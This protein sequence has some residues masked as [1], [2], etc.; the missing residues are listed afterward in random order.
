MF[1]IAWGHMA[2]V[3]A[4]ALMVIRPKDLPAALRTVGRYVGK[5][6]A[7]ARE[8]QTNVDDM[9]RETELDEIK[10]QVDSIQSG[11]IEREIEKVVDPKGDL[12]KAF[13]P[14]EFSLEDKPADKSDPPP[15]VDQSTPSVAPTPLAPEPAEADQADRRPAA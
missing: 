5:A 7:M 14:P 13:E 3:A 1:D 9:I 6:K 12:A 11:S 10:K 15:P 4:V 8:F 2:V